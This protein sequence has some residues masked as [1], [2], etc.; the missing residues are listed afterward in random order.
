MNERFWNKV[1]IDDVDGCWLW[2]A[3]KN[4]RGYGVFRWQG[5]ARL[6]HRVLYEYTFGPVPTGLELDHLCTN[7]PC[8][9]PFHLEPVTHLEN[10]RRAEWILCKHGHELTGENIYYRKDRPGKKECK[11]CQHIRNKRRY[12]IDY[13][14]YSVETS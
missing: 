10:V 5:A 8:V 3:C 9:N 12:Q 14:R 1:S 6:A 13:R 2:I 4:Y 11:V 7:P